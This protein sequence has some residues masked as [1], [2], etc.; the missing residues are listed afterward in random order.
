M[1]EAPL[2]WTDLSKDSRELLTGK[3]AGL[4]GAPTDQAA[5]ESLAIDKQQALI[6]LLARICDKGL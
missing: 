2:Q 6:M 3:L 4:W 1:T 5:F